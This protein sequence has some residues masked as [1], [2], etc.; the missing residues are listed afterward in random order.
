MDAP[1]VLIE[2]KAT[3]ANASGLEDRDRT[4]EQGTAKLIEVCEQKRDLSV[5]LSLDAA[6]KQDQRRERRSTEA[7]EAAEVG[8]GRYEDLRVVESVLEDPLVGGGTQP[9]LRHVDGVVP[10][11]AQASRDARRQRVVDEKPQAVSASG[12]VCSRTASAA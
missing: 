4:V 8:I 12:R 10:A 9:A 2:R 3:E 6:P 1:A 7:Q 11:I 5:H